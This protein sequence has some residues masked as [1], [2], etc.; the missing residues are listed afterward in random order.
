MP[1]FVPATFEP[2]ES[3]AQF[4]QGQKSWMDQA[5][6]RQLHQQTIEK[7][8]MELSILRPVL[9]ARKQAEALGVAADVATAKAKLEEA[10]IQS[11]LRVR[12]SVESK[13]AQFDYLNAHSLAGWDDKA[14]ALGELQQ[15]YSWM[16]S[17]PEGKQFLQNLDGERANAETRSMNDERID[18]AKDLA[19]ARYQQTIDAAQIRAD[20]ER[21]AAELREQTQKEAQTARDQAMMER[22][23]FQQESITRRDKLNQTTKEW[24]TRQQV[25]T[26][27]WGE[28]AKQAAASGQK[29]PAFTIEDM[30]DPFAQGNGMAVSVDTV[31]SGAGAS[32]APTPTAST[33]VPQSPTTPTEVPK[34]S[35]LQEAQ[36]AA[37]IG[38]LQPGQRVIING[39]SG[40]WK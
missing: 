23:K 6:E 15:K 27:A 10:Q 33:T 36:N 34:F 35:T 28:M 5:Q 8:G 32:R 9:E 19:Q 37:G 17:I 39:V 12:Y 22:E 30:P 13:Q 14:N 31:G 16:S 3:P 4:E 21:D 26:R 20:A 25:R 24:E 1:D 2:G 29:V 18:E 38:Q 11:A 40:T 7:Q